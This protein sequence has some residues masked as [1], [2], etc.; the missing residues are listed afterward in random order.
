MAGRYLSIAKEIGDP[1]SVENISLGDRLANQDDETTNVKLFSGRENHRHRR[2]GN[3]HR[4]R[5]QR[6]KKAS[7]SG[8]SCRC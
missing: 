8:M 2:R 5:Y 6:R 3:H 7:R 1:S 4:R